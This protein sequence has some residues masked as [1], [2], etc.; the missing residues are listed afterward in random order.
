MVKFYK[1]L[2]WKL[3]ASFVILILLI[4]S[5]TYVYTYSEAKKALKETVR[6]EL[7]EVAAMAS[8]QIKGDALNKLLALKPGDEGSSEYMKIVSLL[9]GMRSYSTELSNFYIMKKE[10]D[11][12]FFIVDDIYPD[13]YA[14]IGEEYTDYDDALLPGFDGPTASSD[15][16]TDQWGTFLSGYA[17]IKNSD[18]VVVALIGIDMDVTKVV[19]KQDFLGS[20]IYIIM[21]VSILLAALIILFFSATI[22]KDIKRLT[23]VANQISAGELDLQLPEIKSKNEIYEL[24]EGLKSVVAAVE[25]L[26]EEAESKSKSAPVAAVK[27]KKPKPKKANA[28]KRKR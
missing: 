18:G 7:T 5:L 16:Y 21:G 14:A 20:L 22:I 23:K 10:G 6:E 27:T 12:I 13:D 2:Q 24:N 19:E 4:T 9:S 26:K 25:F 11:K 28:K 8:T 15:F 3:T 1:S 17:P